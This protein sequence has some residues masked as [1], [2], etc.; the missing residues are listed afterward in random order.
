MTVSRAIA[1]S[2]A[3]PPAPAGLPPP[4]RGRATA[5]SATCTSPESK[6]R[7]RGACLRSSARSRRRS[8]GKCPQLSTMGFVV[9]TWTEETTTCT[10]AEDSASSRSSHS[11][12]GSPRTAPMCCSVHPSHVDSQRDVAASTGVSFP[13]SEP[14]SSA[15]TEGNTCGSRLKRV[16]SAM[17]F[18]RRPFGPYTWDAYTPSRRRRGAASATPR[19]S[20]KSTAR[21]A[22]STTPCA[23]R[24]PPPPASFTP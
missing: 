17:T 16:S 4:L 2:S 13:I 11:H 14:L 7:P 3:L 9:S 15:P 19:K 5:S 6:T 23:M 1:S 20:W 24:P 12:W 18:T 22:R 10:A 21:C 8:A